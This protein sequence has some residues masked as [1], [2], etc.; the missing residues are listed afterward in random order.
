MKVRV[1]AAEIVA[2][3]KTGNPKDPFHWPNPL[4]DKVRYLS[5]LRMREFNF[6]AP[7]ARA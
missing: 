1:V 5:T 7:V 4:I 6:P 2:K 3:Q